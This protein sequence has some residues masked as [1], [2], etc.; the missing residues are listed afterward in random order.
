VTD[1]IDMREL[2][3]LVA[4]ALRDELHAGDVLTTRQ[5]ASYLKL[6]S[7][8]LEQMRTAGGGPP[9]VKLARM[10]RYRRTD[11][12]SWLSERLR[13]NTSSEAKP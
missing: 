7:E 11:L 8:T 4:D 5:A 1:I 10:V 12:D 6:A 13:N 3:R 9:F 2:A